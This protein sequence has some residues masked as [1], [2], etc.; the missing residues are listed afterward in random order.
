MCISTRLKVLLMVF[1]S[2]ANQGTIFH[3]ARDHRV[4]HLYSDTAADPHDSNR[5]FWF[6][7]VGW[8]LMKKSAAVIE[9]GKKVNLTDLYND[10]LVMWCFAFPSFAALLWGDTFWNG[11]LFAGAIQ[12]HTVALALTLAVVANQ[13]WHT[14]A[15]ALAVC[16]VVLCQAAAARVPSGLPRVPRPAGLE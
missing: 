9:A 6:S 7:H 1:N 5:G 4:H 13:W 14:V 11:F 12:W 15:L 10:P 8:L 2:I 3:G 16:G